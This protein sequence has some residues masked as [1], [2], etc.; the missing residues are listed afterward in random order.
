MIYHAAM[1]EH[2]VQIYQMHLCYPFLLPDD[3]QPMPSLNVVHNYSNT[4]HKEN[5][6]QY[7][8]IIIIIIWWTLRFKLT[9][10]INFMHEKISMQQW[11]AN[12]DSIKYGCDKKIANV[13]DE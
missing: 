9:L 8:L 6:I 12:E 4:V 10:K 5:E 7:E 3:P 11:H 2:T 13:N 1:N